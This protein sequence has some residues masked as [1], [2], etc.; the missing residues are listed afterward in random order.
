MVAG[1]GPAEG[2]ATDATQIDQA[3]ELSSATGLDPARATSA[4]AT[5]ARVVGVLTTL[6]AL[7]VDVA[8]DAELEESVAVEEN[9]A[10]TCSIRFCPT[11]V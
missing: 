9:R 11:L 1:V 5:A 4:A 2:A 6:T 3:V 8:G 7:T 10:T